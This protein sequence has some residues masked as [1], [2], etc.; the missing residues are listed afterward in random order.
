MTGSLSAI[1]A[2]ALIHG[3]KAILID[4]R[5]A[6]EFKAEHIAYAMSVPLGSLE[7][8]F[9]TLKLPQETIVIFHCHKGTRGTMACERIKGIGSCSNEVV[10]IEGGIEGWKTSGLPVITQSG[11]AQKKAPVSI[12][13]Q[14]QMIAG[15]FIAV[16]VV[17]GFS[18]LTLGFVL[19]GMVGAALFL[20][21][22]SGWC[23]MAILLG[24]MPWNK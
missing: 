23:G 7:D 17:I 5:E 9:K 19:A 24:K 11:K 18:G 15:S 3:G 16:F 21:G 6:D 10:N 8:G 1:E 4:V 2:Q 20:S 22:L 12:F 13:R 14:V